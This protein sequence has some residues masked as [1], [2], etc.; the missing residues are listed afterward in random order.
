MKYTTN[1]N[2]YKP[3]YDDTIDVDFLNKNMDVLDNQ[4]NGLDYVRNVNTSD[5]CLTFIKRNG[6]TITV[7]N[8][9]YYP[10]ESGED[11]TKYSDGIIHIYKSVEGITRANG[12][13]TYPTPLK[14]VITAIVTYT[15]YSS[16][17]NTL[18]YSVLDN[19]STTGLNINLRV[20]GG[21]LPAN[22]ETTNSVIV[23]GRWK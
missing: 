19:V 17:W 14:S 4:L 13:F 7:P 5:N 12:W 16:N 18:V 22:Q 2:L 21:D 9:E 8:H 10:V 1:Y 3:D 20:L 6:D 15:N 23:I 11:Y